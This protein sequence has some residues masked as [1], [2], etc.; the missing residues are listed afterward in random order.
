MKS[1]YLRIF[2]IVAF[3][4]FLVAGGVA[5]PAVTDLLSTGRMNEAVRVLANRDDAES[6]NLLSRAYYA[7]DRWDDAVKYGE[8]AVSLEPNNAG[9]HLWLGR[10][11]GRKAGAA[12]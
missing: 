3:L 9:Y 10:E 8:R 12:N 1:V 7:M 2:G 11:Y 6:L 5:A 4:L